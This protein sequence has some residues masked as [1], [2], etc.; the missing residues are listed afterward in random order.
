MTSEFWRLIDQ[1]R[2]GTPDPS[3]HAVALTRGLVAAGVEAVLG[4]AESFDR[5]MDDLYRWDLWGAAYFAFRG[6]GD[7]GFE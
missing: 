4:F 5:A 6:C 7:D 1:T 3:A 2:P